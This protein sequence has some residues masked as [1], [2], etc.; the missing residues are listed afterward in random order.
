VDDEENFLHATADLLRV[1]GYRCDAAM[2]VESAKRMLEAASYDLLITDAML[3]G[4]TDL[5]LVRHLPQIAQGLPV[6]LVTGFPSIQT[7]KKSFALPV[8]AYLAKPL[9]QREF[10]SHV[11]LAIERFQIYR[12][13]ASTRERLQNWR[14]DLRGIDNFMRENPRDNSLVPIVTFLQLTLRNIV[15]SLNDLKNLTEALAMQSDKQDACQI[16]N[17][18]RPVILTSAIVET[19]NVLQRT[20][21]SFKSKEL[22]ELR[23]KLEALVPYHMPGEAAQETPAQ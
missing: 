21:G 13:V 17:C 19:I 11:R 20:K 8:V 1:E 22:G 3:P 6:I 4:N 9:D 12:T 14:E 5:E 15:G 16:L 18:P 23:K 7:A 10:L 2:D